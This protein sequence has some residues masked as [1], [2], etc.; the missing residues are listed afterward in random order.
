MSERVVIPLDWGLIIVPLN[1]H[2]ASRPANVSTGS[3]GE[4]VCQRP[5]TPHV[6]NVAMATP[7]EHYKRRNGCRKK[8]PMQQPKSR[9]VWSDVLGEIIEK[10]LAWVV[11]DV[12][13]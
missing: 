5:C 13:V 1:K 4:F 8:Y 11:D 7:D 10:V 3:Y 2:G 6:A 12:V 9:R